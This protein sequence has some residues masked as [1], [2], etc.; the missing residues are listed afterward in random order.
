M[1]SEKYIGYVELDIA[2]TM[3]SSGLSR[4]VSPQRHLSLNNAVSV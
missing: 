1:N 2:N 4:V 3:P